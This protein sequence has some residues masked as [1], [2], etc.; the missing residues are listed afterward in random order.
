MPLI[1][2]R[3]ERQFNRSSEAPVHPPGLGGLY[4]AASSRLEQRA[5][6]NQ[7]SRQQYRQYRD[8]HDEFEEQDAGA[9]SVV[10]AAIPPKPN[11]AATSEMTEKR[12]AQGALAL[13]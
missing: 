12:R 6:R 8:D 5:A 11:K 3:I 1:V 2:W 9:M 13:I 4:A 7:P 10:A